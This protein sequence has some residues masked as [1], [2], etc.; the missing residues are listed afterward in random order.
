MRP[1]SDFGAQE[2][3]AIPFIFSLQNTE[4]GRTSFEMLQNGTDYTRQWT[5]P[6]VSWMG[7]TTKLFDARCTRPA[8]TVL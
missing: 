2:S 4:L 7:G 5:F 8:S 6:A 3:R 1:G